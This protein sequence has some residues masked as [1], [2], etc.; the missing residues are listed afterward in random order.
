MAQVEQVA[1]LELMD[2]VE[3]QALLVQQVQQERL[4]HQQVH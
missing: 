4:V 2:L 1:Q 3:Q